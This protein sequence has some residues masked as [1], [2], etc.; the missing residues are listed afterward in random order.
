MRRSGRRPRPRGRWSA[1]RRGRPGR[2]PRSRRRGSIGICRRSNLIAF[3]SGVSGS[4]RSKTGTS[5]RLCR[6]SVVAE[7]LDD[8]LLGVRQRTQCATDRVSGA[9]VQNGI[10][11]L[12]DRASCLCFADARSRE[13]S[14]AAGVARALQ[15]DVVLLDRVAAR[16]S[17][18]RIARSSAG[19][20]NASTLPH[21]VH[22]RWWWCSPDVA[23]RLVARDPVADVDAAHEPG[24][25]ERLE[26]AVDAR[27]ADARRRAPRARRRPRRSSSR[28]RAA[29][30]PRRARGRCD[31]PPRGVGAVRPLPTFRHA[32]MVTVLDNRDENRYRQPPMT[33]TILICAWPSPRSPAAGGGRPAATLPVVAS[34]TSTATSRA[35]SAARTSPSPRSSPTRTP[36]RT[37]SS[38][39]RANGLAVAQAPRR[40]PE[41]ARL[42]R[43]H[44]AA[45]ARGAERQR[46][47]SSRSPTCSGS[48]APTPTRTSGTTCPARPRSPPRSSGRS[49]RRSGARRG[50][51][52]GLRAL[53]AS[54]PR[55]SARSRRSGAT[56]RGRAVAYTEPVPGYLIAAAGLREPRARLVHAPDRGRHRAVAGRSLRDDRPRDAARDQ[57][58]PLQQPGRLA[59]HDAHPCGGTAAGIPIVGVTETLPPARRSRRGS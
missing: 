7:Q 51:R 16:A 1:A 41:R 47:P 10:P 17:T 45:R 43:V 58:P 21:S 26:H 33:R 50:Y 49:T 25:V 53:L 39:G 52:R 13:P 6:R 20:S 27:E 31:S 40:D 37:S 18:R 44:V 56:P 15:D 22:T 48:T 23:E 35:R 28:R 9:Q 5:E 34:R 32:L 24:R 46:A 4:R 57:G 2:T 29:R 11:V 38:R 55:C 19:S 30:S 14:V 36:T 12:S 8:R 42:R 54:L 59:D 3:P